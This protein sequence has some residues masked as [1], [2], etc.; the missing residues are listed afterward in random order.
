MNI[1]KYI[2]G[3]CLLV[4]TIGAAQN[5]VPNGGF[6][7]YTIP[8]TGYAQFFRAI[9]WLN[10]NGVT[11]GPPYASPDF[12]HTDGFFGGAFGVIDA[13]S[14]GGQ[15]GFCTFHNGLGEFRE[16]ISIEL[17]TTLNVGQTYQL[18]FY[19][20]NGSGGSYQAGSDN[21]GAHFSEGPL[22]Q[23]VDEPVLVTPQIEIPGVIYHDN[24]WQEYVF[25]FVADNASN[26]ITI[27][28]F[29]DDAS[30]TV[31]GGYRAYYFIDDIELITSENTLTITGDESLCSGESTTLTALNDVLIGWANS[32]SPEV[33]IST[34][35]S[36]TVS[37]TETTTYL[38]YGENDTASFTVSVFDVPV[39]DLG[40]DTTLCEGETLTLDASS[41]GASYSWQD[42]SAGE[43]FN[44]TQQGAYWVEASIGNCMASDTISVN[45]NP[46]PTANISGDALICPGEPVEFDLVLTGNAPWTVVYSIDGVEQPS[47][48]IDDSPFTLPATDEGTYAI[49]SVEDAHCENSGTGSA[50]LEYIPHSTATLSGGGVFCP[51]E[52]ATISIDFTGTAPWTFEYAIDGVVYG[53]V[54]TSEPTYTLDANSSGTY[55]I[56]SLSNAFCE[57]AIQGEAEVE[58]NSP[59][60]V[61]ISP[62]GGVCPGELFG[63]QANTTG[64]KP[65]YS[66]QW[67]DEANDSWVE[68]GE[69]L[70]LTP[71]N[72][73]HIYVVATDQCGSVAQSETVVVYAYAMPDASFEFYPQEDITTYNTAVH[74]F[75]DSSVFE[76]SAHWEFSEFT[77]EHGW[78]LIGTSSEVNPVFTYPNAGPGDYQACLYVM[79][80]GGCESSLC[81]PLEILGEYYMYVPNAFTPNEDGI[82]DL[83]GPVMMGVDP[84]SFEF[85]VLNRWGE[86]LFYTN[87]V[88]QQWNGSGVMGTHYVPNGVYSW[89]ITVRQLDDV[90]IKQ[91][92][93]HVTVIR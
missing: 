31:E 39:I 63:M 62:G 84:A 54:T 46:L 85:F 76:H 6:E 44:V 15:M 53:P 80:D 1:E 38:A 5:L 43:T 52:V 42:G 60:Q 25:T 58:V 9:G 51:G 93:G 40:N 57:D 32:V 3:I 28:N 70:S 27:G 21:F 92:T 14:G 59:V 4:A 72:D 56:V 91:Y 47:L 90:E 33:I 37:P 78:Q 36:M 16:Y 86:T 30:T 48:L 50:V 11:T 22:T 75:G 89:K 65:P 45:F 19:L 8:P 67:F 34:A 69:S 18:T 66:F 74:Y 24:F 35:S 73:M 79:S 64:G 82:N 26:Y 61:E 87:D 23:A 20:T 41:P 88:D 7:E 29:E 2:T 71:A 68:F 81:L 55:S 83:F 77:N 10:L 17:T 12:Y 49:V 13:H